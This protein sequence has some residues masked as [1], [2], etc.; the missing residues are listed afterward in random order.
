MPA[1]QNSAAPNTARPVR[2]EIRACAPVFMDVPFSD[3]VAPA[4]QGTCGRGQTR[5]EDDKK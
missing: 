5:A 1:G 3:R 2:P 4:I